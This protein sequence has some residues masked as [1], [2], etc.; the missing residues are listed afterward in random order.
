MFEAIGGILSG[1]FGGNK[2]AKATAASL[3]ALSTKVNVLEAENTK[4]T[5]TITYLA[6]GLAV[7][8]AVI[9]F[10]VVLKK[11]RG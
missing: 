5:K 3:A 1:L 7:V 11:R 9:I 2:K 10:L 4:Q 8:T 6:I